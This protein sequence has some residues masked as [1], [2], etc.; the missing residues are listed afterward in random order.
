RALAAAHRAGLVHRDV[1]PDNVMV[2]DDGKLKILDFG[3][4][5]RT[6]VAV[7]A[8]APTEAPTD[9]GV[10]LTEKGSFIGT[11]KYAAPEQL[12]GDVD[13]GRSDQYAW[14]VTA[15]EL[16]T[17]VAPFDAESGVALVSRI[18]SAPAPKLRDK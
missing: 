10:S 8:S 18:V 2:R 3:I 16:L 14:A 11:P 6:E 4:A 17:G 7:D 15:F 13:D 1:K 9:S 12:R 5:K